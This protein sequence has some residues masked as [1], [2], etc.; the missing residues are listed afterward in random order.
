MSSPYAFNWDR[1]TPYTNASAADKGTMRMA[2][3]TP[4]LGL[5][6]VQSM[7]P[8]TG[9]INFTWVPISTLS[10]QDFYLHRDSISQAVSSIAS[11]AE[12]IMPELVDAREDQKILGETLDMFNFLLLQK[13]FAEKKEIVK[14]YS[15]TWF[16]KTHCSQCLKKCAAGTKKKCISHQCCGLCEECHESLSERCQVNMEEKC[17]ACDAP[18]RKSVV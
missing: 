5:V 16:G 6:A 18:D 11:D 2:D 9:T 1:V 14:K 12:K 17:S 10:G 4:S 7:S 3:A 13:S 8:I 15:S